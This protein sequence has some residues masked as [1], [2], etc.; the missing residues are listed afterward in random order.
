VDQPLSAEIAS[1]SDAH[2]NARGQEE[3]VAFDFEGIA[4]RREDLLRNPNDAPDLFEI[5]DNDDKLVAAQS[6]QRV[7][8]P[9]DRLEPARGLAQ[10]PISADVAE[11]VVHGFEVVE[12]E[13]K[14]R[15]QTFRTARARERNRKPIVE[16]EPVGQPRER[17]V[18]GEVLDPRPRL[19]DP[20]ELGHRSRLLH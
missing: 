7:S 18:V 9:H 10:Q 15:D 14:N 6:G 17:I 20:R 3:I 8:L 5:L 1:L 4:Y 12:V 2:A 13:K 11:A 19:I 16:Q